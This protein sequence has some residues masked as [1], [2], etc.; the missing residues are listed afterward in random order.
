M[1]FVVLKF[2][3]YK[4]YEASLSPFSCFLNCAVYKVVKKLRKHHEEVC[5][6]A[7]P[8]SLSPCFLTLFQAHDLV[9]VNPLLR[10]CFS[11]LLTVDP[12]QTGGRSSGCLSAG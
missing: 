5:S 1:V 10:G 6:A 2:Y 11:V 4:F 3:M 12:C 7:S 9:V 8:F